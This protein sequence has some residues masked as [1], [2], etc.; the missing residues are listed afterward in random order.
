MTYHVL[1]ISGSPYRVPVEV[2]GEPLPP[3]RNAE[4]YAPVSEGI[5]QLTHFEMKS[6]CK[7]LFLLSIPG[8]DEKSFFGYEKASERPPLDGERPTARLRIAHLIL[9]ATSIPSFLWSEA[10]MVTAS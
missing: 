10:R 8:Q 3:N 6:R 4:V 1:M 5:W 7:V 2:N 9:K